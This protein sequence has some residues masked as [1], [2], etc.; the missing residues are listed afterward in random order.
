MQNN[1]IT[2]QL[3][4]FD[5]MIHNKYSYLTELHCKFIIEN[6]L[7]VLFFR[8]EILSNIPLFLALNF[9][10]TKH[11]IEYFQKKGEIIANFIWE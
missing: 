5:T 2:T 4:T 10:T 3:K 6:M 1:L 11:K 9:K 8:G 7:F